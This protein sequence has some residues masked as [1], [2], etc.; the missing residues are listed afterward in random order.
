MLSQARR[1]SWARGASCRCAARSAR[2]I[3][4]VATMRL[5]LSLARPS[6]KAA[7]LPGVDAPP[8]L[9]GPMSTHE[10][11]AARFARCVTLFREPGARDDQKAEF[12]AL[13]GLLQDAAVSLRAAG[14]RLEING[15][16]CEGEG[17]TGLVQ[18]L[19]LHGIGEIALPAAPPPPQLFQL[20]RAL[21]DQPGTDDIPSRLAAAGV[22]R[23]RVT[24]ASPETAEPPPSPPVASSQDI[25]SH[26]AIIPRASRPT[27]TDGILRGEPWRDTKSVP[28]D[29]VPLVS[30]DP[31]PPPAA[32]ALP[33][34][35]RPASPQPAT[36]PAPSAPSAPRVSR[37]DVGARRPS[38]DPPS[39]PPGPPSP[40][41][42]CS[43]RRT[44]PERATPGR[45]VVAIA[46]GRLRRGGTAHA[47]PQ[48]PRGGRPAG[49]AGAPR[50]AG[51][52]AAPP[53]SVIGRDQRDRAGGGERPRSQRYAP[54]V[55]DR[56]APGLH[57]VSAGRARLSPPGAQVSGRR[58]GGAAAGRC[59]GGGGADGSAG[60]GAHDG[61]TALGLRR[62]A[63]Y[64]R[65]H[66][67]A[68]P[69]AR[70]SRVV[71]GAQRG[72]ADR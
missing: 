35:V 16:P 33:G 71:C 37:A 25:E 28:I 64:D 72:G 20:F 57:Q 19:D 10:T 48:R 8:R 29:G 58:R 70:A 42:S 34:T 2:T 45:R 13:L 9:T 27:G 43:A 68:R 55:R 22:D 5:Y 53:R 49:G 69:R 56:A 65:G 18:R 44:A 66:R 3:E 61:R 4:P 7:A 23:I 31:P 14:G 30:H 41:G 11:L 52:Q 59:G 54:P 60:G 26:E 32:D 47:R 51:A 63:A 46:G 36:P 50:R 12:R 15:I 67:P 38:A 21:A 40:P 24:L 1:S 39:P 17:L 62:A 6:R